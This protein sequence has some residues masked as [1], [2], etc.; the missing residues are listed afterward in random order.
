MELNKCTRCG[1]FYTSEAN[2][3]PS[4]E[5]KDSNEIDKLENFLQ[6]ND[7]TSIDDISY[8]TGITVKNLDRF[9]KLDQFKKF[10]A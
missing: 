2:V 4:C 6:E 3:C 1:C 5:Q 10:K 9:F 7:I 8:Q